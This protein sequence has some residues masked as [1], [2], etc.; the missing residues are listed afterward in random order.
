MNQYATGF[1]LTPPGT[2]GAL[3]GTTGDFLA[4]RDFSKT[5]RKTFTSGTEAALALKH[6]KLALAIDRGRVIRVDR[7]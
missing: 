7:Q 2:I 4:Q 3:R 6:G 5:P 1:P